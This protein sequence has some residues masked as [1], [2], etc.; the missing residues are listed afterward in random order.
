ME[1]ASNSAQTINM[2][3]VIAFLVCYFVSTSEALDDVNKKPKLISVMCPNDVCEGKPDGN[4]PYPNDK[5]HFV[6]CTNGKAKCQ[7]C[8]PTFLEFNPFCNQ[9]LHSTE[10]QCVT[11][12]PMTGC[13]DECPKRG[14]DFTGN[15]AHP[16]NE[17][18][19]IGCW[20]GVTVGC[21]DC[22]GE[23]VFIEK[24]NVCSV[25]KTF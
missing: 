19:F 1:S 23:S 7:A 16:N 24:Y 10:D 15:I 9:C 25:V 4:Y 6:Q 8:W 20:R 22:P 5:N 18:K 11:E 13:P 14:V 21:M 17:K 3:Y 2:K 12:P